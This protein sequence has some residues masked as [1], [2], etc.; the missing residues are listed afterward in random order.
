MTED[1]RQKEIRLKKELAQLR[2][3]NAN[4]DAKLKPSKDF[5]V[6]IPQDTSVKKKL[7][8]S[9]VPDVVLLPPSKRGKKEN[10]P[11]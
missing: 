9:D 2:A 8:S 6:G 5:S 3:M 10:I 11:F 4:A 1:N 7:H